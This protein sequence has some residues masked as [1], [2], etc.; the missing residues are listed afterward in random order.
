MSG[1]KN[2]FVWVI[3]LR[4]WCTTSEDSGQDLQDKPAAYTG[5]T[6]IQFI[7]RTA[8]MGISIS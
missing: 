8:V 2:K 6:P 7:I 1:K 3:I 4:C 5:N